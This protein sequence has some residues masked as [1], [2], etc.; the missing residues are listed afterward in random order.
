VSLPQ[1]LKSYY[2][3]VFQLPWLPEWWARF[4]D[5]HLCRS[6]LTSAASGIRNRNDPAGLALTPAEVEAVYVWN[7][8]Q[9]GMVGAS[10]AYYRNVF[11]GECSTVWRTAAAVLV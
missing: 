11:G 5:Y 10:V 3:F 7:V 1:L 4:G 2:I 6:A 8:S 9:A